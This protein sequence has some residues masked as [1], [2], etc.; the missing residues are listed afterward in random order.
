MVDLGAWPGAWLQVLAE[1]VGPEG[2]VIGV[3]LE[4]IEP[5][6]PPVEVLELDFTDPVAPARIAE[7]LGRPAR[8]IFSD[9]APKLSGISEVDRAAQEELCEAALRIAERVLEPAGCLIIK[10]FPG[11]EQDRFRRLVKQRFARVSEVRP[12]GRRRGS[13][14]LYLVATAESSSGRGPRGRSRR[15]SGSRTRRGTRS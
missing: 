15:G 7:A 1:A 4:K 9:A 10:A 14:E 8:A 2:R 5:L 11:P 12:E 6:G 3:D 13:K